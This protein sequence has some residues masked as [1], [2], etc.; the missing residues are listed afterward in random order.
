MKC[1]SWESTFETCTLAFGYGILI[2]K[3]EMIGINI[4][5]VNETKIMGCYMLLEKLYLMCI[6]L[7]G[8]K[9]NNGR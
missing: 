8:S 9:W 6:E 5:I 4:F 3:I 7:L 1:A 2:W